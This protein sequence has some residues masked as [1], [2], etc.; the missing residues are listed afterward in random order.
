MVFASAVI[1]RC[2]RSHPQKH[3]QN[4][5]L[6]E[7]KDCQELL[8]SLVLFLKSAARRQIQDEDQ[9]EIPS[10]LDDFI[11]ILQK[12]DPV[13]TNS[14]KPVFITTISQLVMRFS[15]DNSMTLSDNKMRQQVTQMSQVDLHHL[16]AWTE[17][18]L[19]QRFA[20]EEALF[21]PHHL[22]GDYIC[23]QVIS[24]TESISAVDNMFFRVY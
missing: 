24:E 3:I 18:P 22:L 19:K 8:A 4:V 1:Y 16:P 11:C 14:E 2:L 13:E 20:H 7:Y 23:T 5:K 17:I 21:V 10:P 9:A 12:K 15:D 6:L